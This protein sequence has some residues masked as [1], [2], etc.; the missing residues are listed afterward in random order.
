MA[1]LDARVHENALPASSLMLEE[2]AQ[3]PEAL[4]RTLREESGKVASLG[5]FL[6]RR[7]VDLIVLVAR[8]SSDNA[9]LFGRYLLE[10]VTSIPVALAAPSVHTLYGA[11]LDLKRALVIGVS[12][13]GQGE[14]INLV[15]EQARASGASTVGI[16]NEAASAMTGLVDETLLMHGGRERSVAA[17]KTFTGQMLHFYMLAEALSGG[18][19]RLGH[20]ALP[21][22]AAR[23]CE[24][25]PA[26]RSMVDRYVFMQNCVIVG[27]GLVYGNAY[28]WAL[29]LMETCYVVAERFSS[30][31]FFHGPL[32]IVERNFPTFVFAPPG[33]TL[34]GVRELLA[35]L[36]ELRADTLVITSDA[37]VASTCTRSIRMP[38]E[39]GEMLA[40]I[41]YI[42]PAQLFSAFLSSAKGLD[43]DVPRSIAKVTRTL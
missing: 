43:P 24:L 2:I 17:T 7:D 41:P 11:R 36:H 40:P 27:R 34:P 1:E 31:D 37:Q 25:G 8:G 21:E 19:A 32:A 28:E 22:F 39:I 35:R 10:I 18:R 30:A 4:A 6:R 20:E 16:T 9:A 14:D 42:I 33:V 12:Q 13:S 5:E 38:A 23:A 26:I 15:L 3:Q 29:K